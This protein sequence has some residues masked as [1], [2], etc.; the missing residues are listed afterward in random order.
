MI[1]ENKGIIY[2]IANAYCR[3]SEDQ[4][5]LVQEIILQLWSSFGNYNPEYKMTIWIYRNLSPKNVNKKWINWLLRG[6]GS[7][8]NEAQ[9]FMLEIEQFELGLK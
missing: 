9:K 8:I 2:K 6:N 4:E 7:Q 5:D 1:G 3:S